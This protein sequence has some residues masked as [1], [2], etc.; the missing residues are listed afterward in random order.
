[1][2][3]PHRTTQP[4]INNNQEPHPAQ[5]LPT[6]LVIP[7]HRSTPHCLQQIAELPQKAADHPPA[8]ADRPHKSA[9]FPH[10]TAD[11]PHRRNDDPHSPR[12][13]P[14]LQGD[15][16]HS[17][18]DTPHSPGALLTVRRHLHRA[19]GDLPHPAS[20]LSSLRTRPSPLGSA[21]YTPATGPH[22]PRTRPAPLD[23]PHA[24][25]GA[26]LAPAA[27]RLSLVIKRGSTQ[28]Q[29]AL[30]TREPTFLVRRRTATKTRRGYAVWS[31]TVP[32]ATR[33]HQPPLD[34]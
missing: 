32:T 17:P 15:L 13:V 11:F 4:S 28:K 3:G 7:P 25:A 23:T 20:A 9:D 27:A 6:P 34:A 33:L 26:E 2:H 16:P 24:S 10:N 29:P 18:R 14:R 30:H 5:S 12:D 8:R 22:T 21:S 1:M 19:A 31:R